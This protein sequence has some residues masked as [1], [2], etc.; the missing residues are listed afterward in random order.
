VNAH[1][2]NGRAERKIRD[3]QDG[4][5]TS[6]LHAI[7]NWP[8]AITVNLWPYAMHY[9]NDVNNYVPRKGESKAPIELFSS[10][11]LNKKFQH[12][13]HFGC[14]VYVLDHNLQAGKKSG[15]KWKERVRLGINL[16]F[17]PQHAKSVHLVL[18]LQSGCVSPQ[19]HCTFD[20]TFESLKEYTIPPSLWQEKA[21]FVIEKHTEN[22]KKGGRKMDD[23]T[24]QSQDQEW[25]EGEE[26]E[27]QDILP[28]PD[29]QMQEE[30][31]PPM[32]METLQTAEPEVSE[33]GTRRSGRIRR[34]P[35]QFKDYIMTNQSTIN[36]NNIEWQ[37]INP[38]ELEVIAQKSITDPNTLYLWQARKEPDFPKF[39]EAMQKEIDAHTEGGHWKIIKRE[40]LPHGATVL[41]TVWSMKRK[42]R[43]SDRQ[44]YKWKARLNIDGSKQVRGLHYQE[45]Y[46]PVVS[47]PT[48][49][50]F[51]IHALLNGW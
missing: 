8:T 26:K 16:G 39:M 33:Q 29:L 41:P 21:H 22:T 20:S 27:T 25:Q 11:S 49:R 45:T 43:I 50:F 24:K 23:Q 3:L 48:T 1:F 30:Q 10:T 12:F 51:L 47:W 7:K 28:D 37:T 38:P 5:R 36:N 14:P 40:K 13:H 46:S 34:P 35:V 32:Q 15:M 2:Q 44:V 42:R 18:S 31:E 4:A 19:F 9:M 6:L 17:S